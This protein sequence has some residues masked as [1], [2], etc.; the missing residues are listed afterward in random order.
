[1]PIYDYKC[2]ACNHEFTRISNIACRDEPEKE[3]CEKCD[4][5]S[6]KKQVGVPAIGDSVRLGLRTHDDGFREVLS[7]IAEKVPKSNLRD[8]LSR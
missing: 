8:K 2:T 6:I 5:K 4:Q 7:K 1:M 3:Q